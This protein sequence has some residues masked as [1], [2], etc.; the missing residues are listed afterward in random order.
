M[1]SGKTL[2]EKLKELR[3]ARGKTVPQ[4]MASLDLSKSGYENREKSDN[5]EKETIL[6]LSK[7][8]GVGGDYFFLDL[9]PAD[10]D[11]YNSCK[12]AVYFFSRLTTDQREFFIELFESREGMLKLKSINPIRERLDKG[13]KVTQSESA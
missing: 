9:S 3:I 11:L 6:K 12:N 13:L 5:F 4:M 2:G 8:L 7:V 1:E 10:Y